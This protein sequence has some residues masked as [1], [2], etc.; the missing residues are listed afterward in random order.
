MPS[1]SVQVSIPGELLREI[2]S[3]A[4]TRKL[5]RSAVVQRALRLYLEQARRTQTDRAYERAYGGRDAEL[6]D[7]LGPMMGGQQWPEK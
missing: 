4:E 3:R 7:E 6:S 2:D 1:R 5:G